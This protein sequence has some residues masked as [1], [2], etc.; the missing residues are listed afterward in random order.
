MR[1]LDFSALATASRRNKFQQAFSERWSTDRE[2]FLFLTGKP[3]KKNRI[4]LLWKFD[5]AG[6]LDRSIWSLFASPETLAGC[7][8]CLPELSP[9]QLEDFLR[10]HTRSPDLRDGIPGL[11]RDS[12]HY[13]GFP[14]DVRMYEQS[15]FHVISETTFS[16]QR[17]WITEKTWL[18]LVN[19]LPFVMSGDTKTLQ[20]LRDIYGLR[21][22]EK[23]LP[24][25]HYDTIMQSDARLDAIVE[26]TKYWLDHI[27]ERSQEINEDIEHNYKQAMSIMQENQ[28]TLELFLEQ[29]NLSATWQQVVENLDDLDMQ[30]GGFYA[31]Y[32]NIRDP[33]WPDCFDGNQWHDLPEKIKQECT[34]VFG[35]NPITKKD[36]V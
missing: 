11:L 23:Y 28:T 30:R 17:P 31:W 16:N 20:Y 35:Y 27:E 36:S 10:T 25:L 1:F 33:S 18:A 13:C 8:S 12:L 32:E 34:E 15:L 5:Q 3:D 21:T 24:K 19:H 7:Q 14:F 6:L 4:R 2:K 9:T 22:F 29:H 26:N